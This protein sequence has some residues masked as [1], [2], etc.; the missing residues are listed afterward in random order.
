MISVDKAK[1]ILSSKGKEYSDKEVKE[2]LR[3]MYIL[4]NIEYEEFKKS[5]KKKKSSNLH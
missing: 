3:E 4:S 5:E 2:I 1:K